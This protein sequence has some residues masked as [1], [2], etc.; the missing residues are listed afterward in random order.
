MPWRNSDPMPGLQGWQWEERMQEA[1]STRLSISGWV[2]CGCLLD[3]NTLFCNG[4][5]TKLRGSLEKCTGL[6]C[7]SLRTSEL[8]KKIVF[9]GVVCK[10]Y[11]GLF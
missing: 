8:G 9:A 1:G 11:Q 10:L 6:G 2:L 5:P 3:P 4:R 7:P